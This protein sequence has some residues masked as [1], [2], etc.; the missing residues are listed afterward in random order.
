MAQTTKMSAAQTATQGNRMLSRMLPALLLTLGTLPST[1]FSQEGPT[2]Q[3]AEAQTT[4]GSA[5]DADGLDE[6]LGLDAPGSAEE[7]SPD[8]APA[9]P[10]PTTETASTPQQ[11]TEPLATIP[12]QSLPEEETAPKPS[13]SRRSLEEIVVTAQKREQSIQD[14]PISI[15]VMSETFIKE[16]GIT[17]L[18]DALLFTPNFRV[19]QTSFSI[20]PQCR[21]FV[22]EFA[23]AAFEPPCGVAIDGTAY[24][25]AYYFASALFD[26]QR[27]EVL[28]GPQG[29]TFGK[30]TTAGVVSVVTKDPSEEYNTNIDLQY[31]P[32]GRRRA[33]LGVGGALL[34]G[35][36]EI[37]IAGLFEDRLGQT[38]NTT[39]AIDPE[40]PEF[41][42]GRDRVGIRTKLLFPDVVGTQ[43]K[44]TYEYSKANFVGTTNELALDE[45]GSGRDVA[46]Y[47][48]QY[49]PD[50]DFEGGNQI[51]SIAGP[52]ISKVATERMQLDWNAS[53][54]DWDFT[55]VANVGNLV[56]SSFLEVIS[57]PVRVIA[58]D[59]GE[60][61]PV[62]TGE[63]RVVSPEL[64]GLLGLESLFGADLG[65]TTLL[66]GT[67]Y[68]N[69]ELK[70]NFI[71]VLLCQDRTAAFIA[72]STN[73]GLVLPPTDCI[74]QATAH[75]RFKQAV[76]TGALF[77]QLTWNM[78]QNWLLELGGRY[79]DERKKAHWDTFYSPGV[80][81]LDPM[82]NKAFMADRAF[83]EPGFQ[84]KISLGYS[85]NQDFNFFL[86]WAQ[87]FKSGGFNAYTVAG[88]PEDP[89][90]PAD[91]RGSLTYGPEK[92]TEF[93][94]DAK[95]TLLD[96]RMRLNVSLYRLN[97][98]D[99]QVL[100][101]VLGTPIPGSTARLTDGYDE[102]VNA[103]KARAQGVEVDLTYLPAD[104]LTVIGALGYND[105]KFLSFPL[106]V[107]AHDRATT[108]NPDFDPETGKCDAAGKAFPYAAKLTPT[109]T[110]QSSLPLGG[111]WGA[112]DGVDFLVGGTAEYVSKYFLS[113]TL[114]ERLVQD[115]FFRYRANIG[116][117][118]KAQGWSFRVT[119][120]NLT[121][122]YVRSREAFD[123]TFRTITPEDGRSFYGQF[124]WGF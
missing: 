69:Q 112:L 40:V 120:L 56:Q 37:R 84:P 63:L 3:P 106:A 78:N 55:A 9:E 21:G 104:W 42:G 4:Q 82:N 33:E 111:L 22:V 26:L 87:G 49:D 24:T 20:T 108:E 74:S 96:S 14:V 31:G 65:K 102:V 95:M 91:R 122:K 77:S 46:A 98:E 54:G 100:T 57:A 51:N 2:E 61:N 101:I 36:A 97:L 27:I 13:E 19:V 52:G 116:V 79:T 7:S 17:D 71:N 92:S 76:N 15:S 44:L 88:N 89:N 75:V 113:S 50:A 94:L 30:N 119:G 38:R 99:F 80:T 93:G 124:S 114:D 81:L 10:A 8:Q 73:V 72:A 85:P 34:P 23:N 35:V 47:F 45:T 70:D 121:D 105:T 68:Q 1:A 109:F 107:C 53:F 32:D 66:L 67:F 25:R 58:S 83:D 59:F 103:G 60:K 64:P 117:G 41:G 48:R 90:R 11:T 62:K 123:G 39:A 115:A 5:K 118:N 28:R 43:V 29:T 6:L 12:V 18:A 110:L 86:R 16:Q